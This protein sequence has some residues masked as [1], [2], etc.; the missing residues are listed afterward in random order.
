MNNAQINKTSYYVLPC[1]KQ[2]ED[3]IDIHNLGF[4]L[5]SALKYTYRAGLKDGET[6]EKDMAKADHFIRYLAEHRKGTTY[7]HWRQRVDTLDLLA[8]QWDGKEWQDDA[9]HQ[10]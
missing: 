4:I 2:L 6:K 7:E 10:A 3:F 8:R 9:L 1:G 5:A